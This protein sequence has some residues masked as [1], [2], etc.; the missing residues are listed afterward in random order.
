MIFDLGGGTFDVSLLAIEEGIF[1][2]KATNGH[3][4]LGGEDFDNKL[5]DFCMADFKKKTDIDISKN[6][7]ALRRLRTQCEKAKRIL[8][9][10]HQTP[11]ECETLAEGQDY[12]TQI[13]R[14]K[15]EELCMDLFRKCMPPVEN[16]LKD[17]GC[18]KMQVHEVVLV[19]GSTRIPKIQSMLS[20][21]F[22]G[23]TLNKSIN[24]D[25]AVAYGAAVQ[26]AILTGQGNEK[27]QELL[28]LDVAPLSLGIETAGGVMTNLI[29]RNTTIPTKKSQIFT[30]YA[31]NQ[32]G[33]MIQVYEGERKMTKDN[34]MLGKFNLEGIPPA[35][36]GVPQIE[37]TFDIDA[38]GILNVSAADKGTG[39]TQKITITNDKGRLSKEE[40]ERMV[41]DAEKFKAEDELVKKKIEAKN[42]LEN[43]C[44]QMRNT[45]NEEK[46]KTVFT[47]DE[48]KTVEEASKEG[49]QWLEAN[50]D[51][52]ADAIEGKQKQLEAK[53]NP[54]MMRVYQASGGPAGGMPG[55]G[56]MPGGPMGGAGGAT[57]AGVDDLD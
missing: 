25:E 41:N 40:I 9:S 4:H 18:S 23:K 24:P 54:I 13:S 28:L 15:F 50:P 31:D 49:V 43:Y 6:P 46:L 44:F 20:E 11:I 38:N 1:E 30:T 55:M 51:A 17:A 7:R 8:S 14:A 12:N 21:F 45:L 32:P 36:R 48:K 34:H 39:K 52:D 5:V 42:A 33:V 27:T 2:V 22:N 57:D 47:E 19:G 29:D 56:G 16:V 10:A 37:V 3:T 53:F 26:A 35:P